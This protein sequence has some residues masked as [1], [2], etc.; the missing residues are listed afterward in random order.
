MCAGFVE[1]EQKVEPNECPAKSCSAT[2]R[3]PSHSAINHAPEPP[4][5]VARRASKA[6]S[7][8]IAFKRR[9]RHLL[10]RCKV[11]VT[12]PAIAPVAWFV[13][14]V[15]VSD[16]AF[17]ARGLPRPRRTESGRSVL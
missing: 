8:A 10:H 13:V 14:G 7:L 4:N 1:E 12:W 17:G 16:P 5:A 11:G 2:H 6:A 3:A 15:R 9:A